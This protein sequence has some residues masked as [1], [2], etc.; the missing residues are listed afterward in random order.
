M[1]RRRVVSSDLQAMVQLARRKKKYV[2]VVPVH[3]GELKAHSGSVNAFALHATMNATHLVSCSTDKS[4]IV[5]KAFNH[6]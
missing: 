4:V 6:P 3:I 2:L 1:A 5:W